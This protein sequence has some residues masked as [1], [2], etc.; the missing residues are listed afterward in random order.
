MGMRFAARNP[1]G[2][3]TASSLT[4]HQAYAPPGPLGKGRVQ[5]RVAALPDGTAVLDF[6]CPSWVA[7]SGDGP[8]HDAIGT[9]A[10]RLRRRSVAAG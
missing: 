9:A 3:R 5:I 7:G 4:T 1:N 6:D 10:L 8:G 2:P